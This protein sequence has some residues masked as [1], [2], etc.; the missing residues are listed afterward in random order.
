MVFDYFFEVG[1]GIALGFVLVLFP[2]LLLWRKFE[3]R[4]ASREGTAQ[5]RR[6]AR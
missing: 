3:G 4:G 6:M 5:V 1:A 2:S